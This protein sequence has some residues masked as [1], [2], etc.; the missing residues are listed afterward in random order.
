VKITNTIATYGDAPTY[1]ATAQYLTCSIAGCPAT[2]SVNTINTLKPV[3]TGNALTV[4]DGAGGTASFTITPS[5]ATNS[6]AGKT[7]VGS[8][9][10][11]A[12]NIANTSG[13][14]SNTISVTGALTVDKLAV[15][16]NQLGISGV[17]RV[18]NGNNAFASLTL[19]TTA[20]ASRILSGD[21]VSVLGTGTYADTNV[22]TN[23][24]VNMLI[25]LTGSDAGNYSLSSNAVTGNLGTI[26]QL[27]SVTYTGTSGGAWS[28]ASNWAGGAIP[29]HANVAQVIIPSGFSV[30]YDTAKLSAIDATTGTAF[31]PTSTIVNNGVLGFANSVATT[32]ANDVSGTGAVNQSGSG[33]LTLSGNNSFS[34]GTSINGSS[35]IVASNNALGTGAVTS[36]GGSLSVNAGVTLPS[37]T[38]NG[39]VVLASD[40]ASTGSQTYNGAVTLNN[41]SNTSI[42]TTL[43][44]NNSTITSVVT[45]LSSANGDITLNSTVAAITTS[46]QSLV[47]NAKA[48]QVVINDQIGVSTQT[49][50]PVSKTYTKTLYESVYYGDTPRALVRSNPINVT[51][52]APSIL[53][54]GDVTTYA[55]QIYNGNVLVG[56]NGRNG[57]TR[58]LLSEDPAI[59]INGTVDDSVFGTHTLTLK[60]IAIGTTV[61]P[62]TEIVGNV[63]ATTPLAS[64]AVATGAQLVQT[65]AY[66]SEVGTIVGKVT[67]PAIINT[68]RAYA[69]QDRTIASALGLGLAGTL[70]KEFNQQQ[71]KWIAEFDQNY[72]GASVVL[73]EPVEACQMIY[74][75]NQLKC[76]NSN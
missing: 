35:L 72:S 53:I 64:I 48:G 65:S 24:A 66:Y 61:P 31:T 28:D 17:T 58:V 14:F 29:T 38:V 39:P 18:Y 12:A 26:T 32:L 5:G 15:A 51:V 49:Y 8:Y 55:N 57:L 70:H 7:N 75:S 9:Q 3:I 47:L 10:L 25:A 34:G 76:A 73:G 67:L 16:A 60:A 42:T 41:A 4:S 6:G 33:A 13:N 21:N 40:I 62:T 74:E 23:K 50:D 59:Q 71:T 27:A 45:N 54:K 19:N 43:S 22:A 20:A 52:N 1:S 2:G 68:T 46:N 11:S 36:T 56:N 63:G 44:Y 69:I 30:S 37:L